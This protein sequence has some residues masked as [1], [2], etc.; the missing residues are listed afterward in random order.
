MD[1]FH[2]RR[3]P[4]NRS[5]KISSYEQIFANGDKEKAYLLQNMT[6][7]YDFLTSK[8]LKHQQ[9]QEL[10]AIHFLALYDYLLFIP[11]ILVTLMS[12]ILAFLVKSPL[13]VSDKSQSMIALTI[14]ILS[15]LSTFG[16]VLCYV[17]W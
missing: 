10:A 2:T 16:Y 9:E 4:T 13:V 15:T 11:S 1:A 12:G 8:I 5:K 3:T 7:S 17:A 6:E 14:A